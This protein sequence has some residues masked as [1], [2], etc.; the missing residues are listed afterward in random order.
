MPA[1]CG[2]DGMPL[3]WRHFIYGSSHIRRSQAQEEL[4]ILNATR[5]GQA[6]KD[7]FE[8]IQTALRVAAGLTRS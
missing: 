1:W 6:D 2:T 8:T 7:N 5:N 4:R 3:S